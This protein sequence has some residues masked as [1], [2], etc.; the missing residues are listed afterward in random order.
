MLEFFGFVVIPTLLL[1]SVLN[2]TI[3]FSETTEMQK[4]FKK[5]ERKLT[6]DEKLKE[7]LNKKLRRTENG[8]QT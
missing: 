2:N 7:I 5:Y 3:L 1:G 4:M 6:T 8:N